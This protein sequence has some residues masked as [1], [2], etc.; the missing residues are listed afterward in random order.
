MREPGGP[1]RL[2]PVVARARSS[3]AVR[4]TV[5]L[6]AAGLALFAASSGGDGAHAAVIGG[7][8]PIDAAASD[9]LQDTAYN[10]PAVAMNPTNADNI[11]VASRIDAPRFACSLHVSFDGGAS[12][13]LTPVNVPVADP[14]EVS[15]F[16]PDLAYGADGTLYM[17]FTSFKKLPT[18]GTVPDAVWLVSSTDGGRSLSDPVAASGP[19]AFQVRIVADSTRPKRLYLSWVQV[20][21][22]GPFGFASAGNPIVVARSSDG[23]RT[24]EGPAPV[25]PPTR[26]R[27]IAPSMAIGGNG[28][29]F[30]VYLDVG[31]DRLDYEG[32]HEGKGGDPYAGTWSLVLARSSDAGRTWAEATVDASV[33]PTTRF[34][35]LFPPVPSVVVDRHRKGHVVIGFQDGRAGDAD[36]WVWRSTDSGRTWQVP[37]RVND[38]LPGDGRHQYLPALAISRSGRVDVVYYDRRSDRDDHRNH[39]SLQ[40]SL[41]GGRTFHPALRLSTRSFDSRI[42]LGSGRGLADLGSRLGLLSTD[43]GALAVWTDTRAGTPETGKQDL[44]RAV[45]RISGPSPMRRLLRF[46]GLG[47]AG[48]GTA[49]LLAQAIAGRRRSNQNPETEKREE[50]AN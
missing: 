36:V 3:F 25:S 27:V 9:H 29:L 2:S 38:T 5:V 1:E 43:H 46:G 6:I 42:G 7:D 12:W 37:T 23:G 15:C 34:L 49:L 20:S 10:S 33:S 8:V 26:A 35:Q 44:S 45:V 32:A 14:G 22:S 21:E 24:W 39:V 4:G 11:A 30:V 13:T 18:L 47:A 19:M 16:A 31:D 41:D 50:A 28:D 48:V 17:A 40:S